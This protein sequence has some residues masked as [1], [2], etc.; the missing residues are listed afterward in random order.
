VQEVSN[1]TGVQPTPKGACENF[2]IFDLMA[3]SSSYVIFIISANRPLLP[4][5]K[6]APE[7]NSFPVNEAPRQLMGLKLFVVPGTSRNLGPIFPAEKKR[8]TVGI[9]CGRFM[10]HRHST[11]KVDDHG[12]LRKERRL[13]MKARHRYGKPTLMMVP[14]GTALFVARRDMCYHG[15]SHLPM[16]P[17]TRCFDGVDDANRSRTQR[18]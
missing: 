10:S 9:M 8:D 15:I 6:N 17:N 16:P 1:R 5:R 3:S 11:R 14:E 12:N 13:T 7:K 2:D 4:V 18:I